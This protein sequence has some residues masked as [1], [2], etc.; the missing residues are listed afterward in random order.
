MPNAFTANANGK[1]T[2]QRQLNFCPLAPEA[3]QSKLLF[4][5][6]IF[7]SAQQLFGARPNLPRIKQFEGAVTH[8]QINFLISGTEV[9]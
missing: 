7:H 4:I 8:S 6:V 5:D 3:G 2:F 1:A 9:P